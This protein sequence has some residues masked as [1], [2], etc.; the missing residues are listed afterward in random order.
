[1]LFD[2]AYVVALGGT[3]FTTMKCLSLLVLMGVGIFLSCIL[4][5]EHY[6]SCH[7]IPDP[8]DEKAMNTYLTLSEEDP[9]RP[10]IQEV[11]SVVHEWL[12][13]CGGKIMGTSAYFIVSLQFFT[14]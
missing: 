3:A 12:Q 13:V 4:Q 5:W 11:V 10:L 7:T 14:P 1:M 8:S 6:V 9:A 2:T